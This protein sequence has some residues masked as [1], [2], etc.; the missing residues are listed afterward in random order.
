MLYALQR[1]PFNT[2][3]W[4]SSYFQL[5]SDKLQ[6][7]LTQY[8]RVPDIKSELPEAIS[9]DTAQLAWITD[10]AAAELGSYVQTLLTQLSAYNVTADH[11]DADTAAEL[12]ER[13]RSNKSLESLQWSDPDT[14]L[15]NVKNMIADLGL[16]SE[17]CAQ[18][19]AS[20]CV[21]LWA[22][23][24]RAAGDTSHQGFTRV[25]SPISSL[26][27]P[28]KANRLAEVADTVADQA[29]AMQTN[30][31]LDP[32]NAQIMENSTEEDKMLRR[33]AILT[34]QY[35]HLLDLEQSPPVCHVYP[36]WPN[37]FKV[38]MDSG[39]Q[40]R[41][42]STTVKGAALSLVV[43]KDPLPNNLIQSSM[44][45]R[46]QTAVMYKTSGSYYVCSRQAADRMT[47]AP[48]L[49]A[50]AQQAMGL[51]FVAAEYTQSQPTAGKRGRPRKEAPGELHVWCNPHSSV[52]Q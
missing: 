10:R 9:Q 29:T 50:S 26:F 28:F 24:Q 7:Q 20:V 8:L 17:A 13:F 25:S 41:S 4:A 45:H 12:V 27:L 33:A 15:E 14:A 49:S 35:V 22:A 44:Y 11:R 40:Q 18:D 39:K 47:P 19:T 46:T 51:T 2:K 3:E 32:A 23:K 43:G 48:G 21:A 52:I 31:D 16:T 42:K 36:P 38:K 34:G 30:A 5:T 1:R 6:S 37:T